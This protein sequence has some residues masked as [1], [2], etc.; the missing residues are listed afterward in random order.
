[1]KKLAVL[2]IAIISNFAQA[3]PGNIPDPRASGYEF[4]AQFT[5]DSDKNKCMQI[6]NQAVVID[7]S[8]INI[9]RTFSFDSKKNECLAKI[10]NHAF[11]AKTVEFCNA[12]SFDS[13]KMECVGTVAGKYAPVGALTV[14]ASQS[15]DSKK[16]E[17][18]RT[19]LT[20]MRTAPPAPPASA[21][22]RADFRGAL[23]MIEGGVMSGRFGVA[24]Q[25]IVKMS[26]LI[27][28]C[29]LR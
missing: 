15:F 13:T 28:V 29:F 19:S 5:F 1:M 4:C 20:D 25:G 12:F 18:L 9:C 23:S 24:L 16:M 17:C 11:D 26:T 10:V 3:Q 27:D 22:T 21:C 14:C 2:F 8:A 7:S 6:V